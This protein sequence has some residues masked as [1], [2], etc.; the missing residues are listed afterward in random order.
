MAASRRRH[1]RME[2]DEPPP[3][4]LGKGRAASNMAAAVGATGYRGCLGNRRQKNQGG[5]AMFSR[6]ALLSLAASSAAAPR[7]A[8]AQQAS[9]KVA[10]YANVGADLTHYDV[11]VAGAELV[12]EKPSPPP[13]AGSTP[14]CMRL[15]CLSCMLRPAAVLPVMAR[16]GLSTTSPRSASTLRPAHCASTEPR[17]GYRRARSTSARTFRPIIFW[18]RSTIRA[19]CASTASTRIFRRATR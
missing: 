1:P 4:P 2:L 13:P 3:S 5:D 17:Y 7:L 12:R 6:R 18:W 10:L 14:C 16:P 8:S 19:R 9:R 15:R 11:D